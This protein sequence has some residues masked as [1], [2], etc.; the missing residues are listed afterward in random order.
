MCR[1]NR[2]VRSTRSPSTVTAT[3]SSTR[4][5]TTPSEVPEP[6][7]LARAE[8][9]VRTSTPSVISCAAP[10]AAPN[11]PRVTISA[12]IRALAISRPLT[13]PQAPPP[14]RET[15]RPA[16]ITPQPASVASPP[17]LSASMVFAPTTPANT[18]TEPTDRSMPA[19]MITKVIP[20]ASTSSTDASIS[21]VCA[22]NRV[23]KASGRSAPNTTH[24]A[25]STRPIHSVL[26][27]RSRCHAAG[28]DGSSPSSG[29]STTDCF[30]VVMPRPPG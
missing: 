30:A 6:R 18:S 2:V 27:E 9:T 3:A 1:P 21:R 5:G 24:S 22:V 29:V 12:G 13:R 7:V 28:R 26:A 17:G 19:V 20:T 25:S 10:R 8:G 4:L 14:S 16:A 15:T 23:R 11:E